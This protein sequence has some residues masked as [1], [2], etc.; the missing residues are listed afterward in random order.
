[1]SCHETVTIPKVRNIPSLVESSGLTCSLRSGGMAPTPLF[2]LLT[3]PTEWVGEFGYAKRDVSESASQHPSHLDVLRNILP[4]GKVLDG[5]PTLFGKAYQED[6]SKG[7]NTAEFELERRLSGE[8]ACRSI[9]NLCIFGLAFGFIIAV[10]AVSIG[11]Y[12]LHSGAVP[13]PAFLKGTGSIIGSNPTLFVDP[14][15]EYFP[16]HRAFAISDS[17]SILLPLILNYGLTLLFDCMSRIHS[18][19]LR[20]ALWQEGNLR[21]NSNP[22][23]FS[24]SWCHQ[25]NRWYTNVFSALSLVFAYGALGLLT[26]NIHV[27][28]FSDAAGRITST[29]YRGPKYGIDFSGWALLFLGITIFV[30]FMISTWSLLSC[31][32]LVKTWNPNALVALRSCGGDLKRGSVIDTGVPALAFNRSRTSIAQILGGSKPKLQHQATLATLASTSSQSSFKS[33]SSKRTFKTLSSRPGTTLLRPSTKQPSARDVVPSVR[34]LNI[35]LWLLF[36]AAVISTIIVAT[37]STV[38]EGSTKKSWVLDYSLEGDGFG[39]FWNWWGQLWFAFALKHGNRRE[40]LAIILQSFFQSFLTL[41]LHYAELLTDVMR[42]ERS[43]RRAAGSHGT[44]IDPPWL[45][46]LLTD[47]PAFLLFLFNGPLGMRCLSRSG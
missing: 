3:E 2:E 43:W 25:P 24:A 16:A 9:R 23:L 6:V 31:P 11:S 44:R 32:R 37:L 13:P 46:E 7:P 20:W 19:T 5:F 38:L 10:V 4:K 40:W 45:T 41:G 47:W 1:M 39:A 12:L 36:T 29:P 42:D 30:Q 14:A 21:F 18:T 26:T 33:S 34:R 8:N 35:A 22:R 17:G 28:G 27:L 15:A